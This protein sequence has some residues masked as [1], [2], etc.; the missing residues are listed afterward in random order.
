VLADEN[1]KRKHE[2]KIVHENVDLAV[3]SVKQ[4][5]PMYF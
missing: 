3:F 2:K 4:E 5:R 1:K